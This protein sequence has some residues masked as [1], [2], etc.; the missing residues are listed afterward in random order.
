MSIAVPL[1]N[2]GKKEDK[3]HTHFIPQEKGKDPELGGGGN[4]YF[5]F[6]FK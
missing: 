4:F 5:Y 6:Y 1:N 2:Q 3:K